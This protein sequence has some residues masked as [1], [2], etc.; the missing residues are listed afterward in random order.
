MEISFQNVTL[1]YGFSPIIEGFS[2][3]VPSGKHA[4]L[5]GV[6]GSGKTTILRTV[7]GFMAP[8]TG[9]VRVGEWALSPD[10]R[11]HIRQHITWLP[12]NITMPAD[13]G[14]E[15]INLLM[16]QLDASAL[17]STLHTYLD[18]L[19]LK[20]RLLNKD[21]LDLS[22]GQKQRLM[23]A[24]LLLFKR[25]ILLLDEPTS[26]LDEGNAAR[27]ADLIFSLKNTTVLTSSHSPAWI[28]RCCPVIQLPAQ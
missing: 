3:E 24:I 20:P 2:F 4:C 22:L 12:Q 13:T 21:R 10:N 11:H 15:M 16:P 23:L 14:Q 9:S 18:A 27:L 19:Q 1:T 7:M 17:Q 5:Q 25:P 28:E 8:E 26:A 6:S